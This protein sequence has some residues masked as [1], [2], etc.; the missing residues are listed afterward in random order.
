VQAA[1]ILQ[2]DCGTA[3]H[4]QRASRFEFFTLPVASMPRRTL[5]CFMA[6]RTAI[7]A[8]VSQATRSSDAIDG[9]MVPPV[10]ARTE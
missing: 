2:I 8:G 7:G 3:A 6:L 4:P 9:G 10:A 5:S 1:G